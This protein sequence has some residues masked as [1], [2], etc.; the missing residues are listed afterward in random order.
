MDDAGDVIKGAAEGVGKYT[1][2][3][4]VTQPC[5]KIGLNDASMYPPLDT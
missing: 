1:A 5:E 2:V 3:F 4:E